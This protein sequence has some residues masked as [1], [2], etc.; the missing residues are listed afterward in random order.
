MVLSPLIVSVTGPD[1]DNF[2]LAVNSILT[3]ARV[4]TV[5]TATEASMVVVVIS[6]SSICLYKLNLDSHEAHKGNTHQTCNDECN[7]KT[8]KRSRDV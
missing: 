5:N 8:T 2:A 4:T 1:G 7:A 3:K 6:I